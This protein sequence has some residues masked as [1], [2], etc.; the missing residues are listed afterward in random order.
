[1]LPCFRNRPM[2]NLRPTNSKTA[3]T[4]LC[5]R[6]AGNWC[7]GPAGPS[8]WT[9]TSTY[10]SIRRGLCFASIALPKPQAPPIRARRAT[11]FH[12]SKGIFGILRSVPDAGSILVG[13]SPEPVIRRYFSASSKAALRML[14]RRCRAS[15]DQ[16]QFN[17]RKPRASLS[18]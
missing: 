10:F 6:G 15:C 1:M 9:G 13:A 8:P 18:R 17:L 5:A 11:N 12:G 7:P 4:R 14:A 3:T 16:S 2:R